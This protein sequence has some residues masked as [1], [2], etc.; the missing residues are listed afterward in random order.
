M[1]LKFITFTSDSYS[2]RFSGKVKVTKKKY[3][4]YPTDFD[5]EEE[6]LEAAS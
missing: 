3:S 5:S 1:S 4:T 6:A 2:K